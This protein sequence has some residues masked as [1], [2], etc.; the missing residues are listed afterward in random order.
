ML[1]FKADLIRKHYM[2]REGRYY[3]LL[4]N[5]YIEG[6]LMFEHKWVKWDKHWDEL[7]KN[8]YNKGRKIKITGVCA[9]EK[10]PYNDKIGMV[11][12]K[13][14]KLVNK[15]IKRIKYDPFFAY[16]NKQKTI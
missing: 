15:Q 14:L 9:L 6:K 7:S 12:V 11:K 13:E 4:H 3:A 8:I 2:P 10:Y 5:I 16:K 1:K